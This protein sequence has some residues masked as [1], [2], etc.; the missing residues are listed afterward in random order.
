MSD[1]SRGTLAPPALLKLSHITHH[2]SLGMKRHTPQTQTPHTYLLATL[3]ACTAL[4]T[5]FKIKTFTLWGSLL[6][7]KL[8]LQGPSW[9][10]IDRFTSTQAGLPVT[11]PQWLGEVLFAAAAQA[12]G[13]TLVIM[14]KSAV[15]MAMIGVLWQ[16]MHRRE[17]NALVIFW[18][19]LATVFLGHFRFTAGP[20]VFTYLFLAYLA[21]RLNAYKNGRITRLW[22]IIPLMTLW[23]NLHFGSVF[24]LILLGTYLAAAIM[25]RVWPYL[26]DGNLKYPV[27]GPMLKHL[28]LVTVLSGLAC[29]IN[30]AGLGFLT[31]P[32]ET[33]YL[34]L[35]YRVIDFFPPRAFPYTLLP[36][37]WC[38]LAFY[39]VVVFGMIRRIDVFDLLVFLVAAGLA[40]KV[41]NLIPVF[42]ILSAP[43]IIHYLS[44]LVKE[45]AWPAAVRRTVGHRGLTALLALVLVCAFIVA[46]GGPRSAYQFGYGANSHMLPFGVTNFLKANR[47]KGNIFNDLDW[48]GFLAYQLYPD[49]KVFMVN[50]IDAMGEAFFQI[51]FEIIAGRPG[52]DST[53]R[54]QNV[55]IVVLSDWLAGRAPLTIGLTASPYWHLVYKDDEAFVYIRDKEEWR[56]VIQIFAYKTAIE[57]KPKSEKG[58]VSDE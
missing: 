34:A 56:D 38:A 7:G 43:V 32:L 21:T 1:G 5:T 33:M 10:M 26:F 53:L 36:L 23:T 51:Y 20:Q 54:S 25:A 15:V 47:L 16:D 3:L 48:G 46:K 22:H 49:N 30:P 52:W 2:T 18:I 44:L 29:L 37:F 28:A 40:L 55:D 12:G 14:L 45:G 57:R 31:Y 42:A 19:A 17:A 8:W 50:R 27:D 11:N 35:Q 41:V 4:L 6:N 24:G 9:T 39:V 58:V 13:L